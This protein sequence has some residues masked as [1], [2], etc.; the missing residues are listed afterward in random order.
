MCTAERSSA[1]EQTV[2]GAAA[3]RLQI[4]VACWCD[5]SA[6]CGAP[7]ACST[8]ACQ[9]PRVTSR[10]RAPASPAT[11]ALLHAGQRWLRSR[12]LYP[13]SAAMRPCVR[14]IG[15]QLDVAAQAVGVAMRKLRGE[16]KLAALVAGPGTQH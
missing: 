2:V 4:Q 15:L 11:R 16:D 8:I 12:W 14:A 7:R 3:L 6:A 1:A 10:T 9:T 5:V 13:A